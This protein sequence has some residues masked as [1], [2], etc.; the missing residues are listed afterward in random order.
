MTLQALIL[1]L[2]SRSTRPDPSQAIWIT[3]C[4]DPVGEQ[5]AEALARATVKLEDTFNV[6]PVEE[7]KHTFLG[8]TA[9]IWDK[10]TQISRVES[11]ADCLAKLGW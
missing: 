2:A 3:S 5:Y 7:S 8:G 1:E 10:L 6:Y 4:P 11:W 9:D